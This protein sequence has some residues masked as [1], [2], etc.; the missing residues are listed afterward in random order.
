MKKLVAIFY[1][2]V[3]VVAFFACNSSNRS[4]EIAGY[5]Q[6]GAVELAEPLK[7]KVGSWIK[8]GDE[9]YG[10]VMVAN[11]GYDICNVREVKAKVLVIQADKIKMKSLEDVNLAPKA[12]CNKM[13]IAKGE[14]WWEEAGDLFQTKE[15]AAAYAQILREA[16]TEK[17]GKKFTVD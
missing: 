9:C 1:L 3:V 12:G 4:K 6:S 7:S 15:E 2:L 13:G 5:E 8:E 16:Q 17:V 14:T 11:P 10:I